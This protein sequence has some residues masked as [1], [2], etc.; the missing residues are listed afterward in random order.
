MLEAKLSTR[1]LKDGL[2]TR[3]SPKSESTEMPPK[4]GREE[5][6]SPKGLTK[7]GY[8]IWGDL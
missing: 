4:A 7:S 6:T 3:P 2:P 1:L 8:F 5:R